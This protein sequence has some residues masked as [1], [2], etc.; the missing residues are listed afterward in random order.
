MLGQ[1]E[2]LA[3][4]AAVPGHLFQAS[5]AGG[6]HGHLGQREEAVEQHQHQDNQQNSHFSSVV[7]GRSPGHP[8]I[9]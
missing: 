6:D 2:R 4:A 9:A 8:A 7:S 5:L 1:F 3:G